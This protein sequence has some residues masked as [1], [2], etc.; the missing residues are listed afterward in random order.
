MKKARFV[1]AGMRMLEKMS[2]GAETKALG[3]PFSGKKHGTNRWKRPENPGE[4]QHPIAVFP[5]L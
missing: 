1:T 5:K 4:T 3:Q 2:P